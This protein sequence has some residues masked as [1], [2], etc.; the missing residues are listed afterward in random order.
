MIILSSYL[1]DEERNARIE[2]EIAPYGD[3]FVRAPESREGR[4]ALIDERIGDADI[5]LGGRLT[6]EQFAAARKLRW[7]HV[8]WAGVNSLLA[9]DA[10]RESSITI[11][12]SSG[13]MSDA[14]AD[15]TMA[16]VT[17]L[18]RDL[19][20]QL[21]ARERREWLAYETESPRRRT[22]RGATLGII[23]YGA[24][25][26]GI[27][28]RARGFGMRITITRRDPSRVPPEVDAVYG[29][30]EVGKLLAEADF[31]V[32]AAPLNE[33]TRGMIGREEIAMM[34]PGAFLINIARG[35]IID[36]GA[37]IDALRENAITG[38]ALDV[39]EQ[40]PLPPESPLWT[41]E[42]ATITPHSSGGYHGFWTVTVDLFLD[43]LD[44]FR[45]GEEPRNRV[46]AA[47]GY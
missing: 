45:R 29:P 27:A 16:Y 43:N 17:M 34:K 12:N 6:A 35:A 11:T 42:N 20:R 7:I 44:R 30:G 25:G 46:D 3:T 14:V 18:S 36:E 22:L 26:R 5:F 10:I 41:M 38:A 1:L 4:I 33:T 32:I 9:V 23:G 37:L 2:A 39:F 28:E 31:V 40:E 47:R 19:P 13:V 15:Q 24:I 8:P 21:R